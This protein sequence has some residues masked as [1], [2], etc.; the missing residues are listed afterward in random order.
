M[1]K[2]FCATHHLY[3]QG[4]E[5]SMC[6]NERLSY[7][8]HKYNVSH[9]KVETNENKKSMSQKGKDREINEDDIS[10]LMNKFNRN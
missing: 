3:Y 7:Y 5:C 9:N 2:K 1:N 8:D 10:K 6:L 4:T